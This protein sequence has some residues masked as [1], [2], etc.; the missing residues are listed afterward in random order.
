[1]VKKGILAILLV[2][3]NIVNYSIPINAEQINVTDCLENTSDCEEEMKQTDTPTEVTENELVGSDTFTAT[4]LV[5]SIIKMII[6]LFFVLALIYF[7]LIVLKKRNNLLNE[8]HVLENLGGIP[9]GQ[10]K[11]IQLIRVGSKIYSV[12][13]GDHVELLFEVTEDEAIRLLMEHAEKNTSQNLVEKLFLNNKREMKKRENGMDNIFTKTLQ[14]ELTRLQQNRQRMQ[15][16][17]SKK[18]DDHV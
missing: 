8:N 2:M 7:I 16:E 17:I 4:S 18:D 1:M 10:N 6:A 12:G 13:V 3:I 5:F 15:E 14:E 11:S 9:L